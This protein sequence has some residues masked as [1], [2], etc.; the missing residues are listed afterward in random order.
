MER[1]SIALSYSLSGQKPIF[2]EA[3]RFTPRF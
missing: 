2:L 1:S 3:R